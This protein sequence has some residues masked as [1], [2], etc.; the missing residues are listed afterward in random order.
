MKTYPLPAY[1][2]RFFTDRLA[3][4]LH[5]SPNT[6]TSYRDTFRLLLK[7]AAERLGRQPTELQ[8]ADLDAELI[9]SFLTFVETRR[10][11]GAR[12][13]NVRL[14]AI[15]SFFKYVAVNEPQLLHHCQQL[16]AVPSKRY[17]KRIID[18]LTRV[19]IEAIIKVADLTT[20]AG[21]RD[22][23][24]LLLALQTGLRVSGLINLTCGDVALGTGAHVRCMG[25][26]RKQRSTPLRKDCVKVIHAWL[27]ERAGADTA[28][29]FVSNRGTRLSR[30]AVERVV[31]KHV[32]LASELCP[33]LKGKRV[34]PHVLRHSAA[35]QLLQN[36]VDRTVIALWLGHESVES[37]QMY[38]H[39]DI[40]IK[41][42]AMA[43]TQPVAVSGT[44][45]R[46]DDA[47][48]AFLEGL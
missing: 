4:Q 21:R 12:S 43:K 38:L 3:T 42:Q 31:R 7:Y 40:Q 11:N 37:T 23:T 17:E 26:G 32:V 33:T 28:P 41:E 13:R 16:L 14:S 25:K 6:V 22:R 29:L 5:A 34:T 18:Y 48:L 46:P 9:G 20:W 47:L 39:A 1:V 15:R 24:L 30:D 44:R 45:Y 10:G 2:Q 19:E 36:G 8:I 35:M 27:D